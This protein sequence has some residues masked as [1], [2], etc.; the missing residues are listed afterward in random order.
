VLAPD[1]STG[2]DGLLQAREICTLP[3]RAELVVLSACDTGIA[4]FEI[5]GD[6]SSPIAHVGKTG[7]DHHFTR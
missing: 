5:I 6:G 4:G 3:I 1:T 2:E 7:S